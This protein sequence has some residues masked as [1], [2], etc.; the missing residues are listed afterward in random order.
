M[1]TISLR[2]PDDL[3]E[4]LDRESGL[5]QRARSE[6]L[7]DALD[8]YLQEKEHERFMS[9]MVREAQAA[10]A[11]TDIEREAREIAEDFLPLEN[12]ALDRI[13][14]RDSGGSTTGDAD[15]KWWK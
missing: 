11:N 6:I 3:A 10:Y 7:R 8:K 4:K 12:E 2:L 5:E 14:G 13:E 1:S 9:E 15:S